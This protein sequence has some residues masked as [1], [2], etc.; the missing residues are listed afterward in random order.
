[1]GNG[2]FFPLLNY[3]PGKDTQQGLSPPQAFPLPL[4]LPRCGPEAGLTQ[5][6]RNGEGARTGTGRDDPRG[7]TREKILPDEERGFPGNDFLYNTSF[8]Q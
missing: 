6:K 4:F 7:G 3:I 5:G 8:N 1:M 2:V